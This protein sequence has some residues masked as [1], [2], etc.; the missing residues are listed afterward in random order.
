MQHAAEHVFV[1]AAVAGDGIVPSAAAAAVG[2]VSASLVL[3][4]VAA[5]KYAHGSFELRSQGLFHTLSI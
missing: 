3:A 1:F 5:A 2:M 4:D